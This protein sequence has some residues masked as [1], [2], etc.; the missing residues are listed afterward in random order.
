MGARRY[1]VTDVIQIHGLRAKGIHGVLPEERE[2]A[3]PFEVDVDM[4]VDAH[5]AGETDRLEDTVDYGAVAKAVVACVTDESHELIERLAQR[6][7]DAVL[8]DTRVQRVEVTVR[9]LQPPLDL[10]LDHVAVHIV[11]P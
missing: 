5:Q 1:S 7:A 6:I 11:R 8:A 10:D 9:K 4:H 2:R 3:Q